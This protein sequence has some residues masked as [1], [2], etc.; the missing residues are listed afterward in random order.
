MAA[1]APTV[2]AELCEAHEDEDD[3]GDS[4]PLA[5]VYAGHVM[6]APPFPTVQATVGQTRVVVVGQFVNCAD[7]SVVVS[8]ARTFG[9]QDSL[10]AE[11]AS[12]HIL[13]WFV[14][15]LSGAGLRPLLLGGARIPP[16]TD[17]GP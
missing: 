12:A 10:P 15:P 11:G 16:M 5:A 9:Y 17:E 3:E 14:G 6:L 4:G 8:S 1:A 13:G 7:S 2:H